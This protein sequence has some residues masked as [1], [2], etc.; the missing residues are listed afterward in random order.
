[1][2]VLKLLLSNHAYIDAR[3]NK[4]WTALTFAATQGQKNM[5]NYLIDRGADVN[6]NDL[7]GQTILDLVE[8]EKS[9]NDEKKNS[10]R[11]LLIENGATNSQPQQSVSPIDQ[12][13]SPTQ[14]PSSADDGL[15]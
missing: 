10:I 1:M 12:A 15:E 13:E 2:K 7:K 14:T 9:L 6:A 8:G 4:E 11:A 5:A 3:S